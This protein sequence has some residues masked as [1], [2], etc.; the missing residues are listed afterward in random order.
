MTGRPGPAITEPAAVLRDGTILLARQWA[1]WQWP[2]ELPQPETP[3]AGEPEKDE[4]S[5]KKPRPVPTGYRAVWAL[6]RLRT[7]RT[8]GTLG[9]GYLIVTAAVGTLNAAPWTAIPAAAGWYIAARTALHAAQP[10]APAVDD[11]EVLAAVYAALGDAD[12]AHLSALAQAL[13][14]ALPGE[15]TTAT[16]R[17]WAGRLDITITPSVRIKGRK[18]NTGIYRHHLPPPPPLPEPLPDRSP[19]GQTTTTTPTDPAIEEWG[20]GAYAIR[21]PAETTARHHTL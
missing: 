15:W 3:A 12:R 4:E 10:P 1:H 20:Q 9:G 5:E 8:A 21:Y 17:A 7:A 18:V 14:E 19:A 6:W 11:E 2:A 16:V 13:G